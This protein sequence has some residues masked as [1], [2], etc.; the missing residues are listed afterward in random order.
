MVLSV[1]LLRALGLPLRHWRLLK[2]RNTAIDLVGLRADGTLAIH[3][4]NHTE[5]LD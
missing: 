3:E 5:H 4:L 1:V 2:R